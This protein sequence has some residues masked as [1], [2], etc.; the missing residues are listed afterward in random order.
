MPKSRFQPQDIVG[1]VAEARVDRVHWIVRVADHAGERAQ[2]VARDHDGDVVGRCLVGVG[3]REL[4]R[5]G[6]VDHLEE[7]LDP[8]VLD[9][10]AGHLE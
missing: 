7:Q 9:V 4:D 10:E 8:E 5:V 3:Q 2:V 1:A 6:V